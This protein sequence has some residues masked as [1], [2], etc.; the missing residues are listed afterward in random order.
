MFNFRTPADFD[1]NTGV[2]ELKSGQSAEFS[3]LYR[4][5]RIEHRFVDGKYTNLLHTARF[6]NQGTVVSD[7]TPTAKIT[8]TETGESKVI[9]SIEALTLNKNTIKNIFTQK[10][11][12]TS[13]KR[14]FNDIVNKLKGFS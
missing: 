1:D 8:N 9:D 14:K 10:V 4:V 11:D 13:I 5:V 12:L 2:Y 7:P 3:G 6:D